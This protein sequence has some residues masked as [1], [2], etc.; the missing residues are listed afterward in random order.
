MHIRFSDHQ[1]HVTT[2][3]N[4]VKVLAEHQIQ[5]T[6]LAI[7]QWERKQSCRALVGGRLDG[8]QN[9]FDAPH[10]GYFS[11]RQIVRKDSSSRL[12]ITKLDQ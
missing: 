1:N 7:R 3:M 12:V 2:L 10:P 6:Q 4:R 9:A 5:H 11:P 8:V